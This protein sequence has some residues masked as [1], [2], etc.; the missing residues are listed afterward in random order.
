MHLDE[1]EAALEMSE[2]QDVVTAQPMFPA[3]SF[4]LSSSYTG[5]GA[6]TNFGRGLGSP[7]T[8]PSSSAQAGYGQSTSHRPSQSL[9]ATPAYYTP[10]S[11]GRSTSS[12]M[13]NLTHSPL[14]PTATG[15]A[16]GAGSTGTRYGVALN[17]TGTAGGSPGRKWG[18]GTPTCPKCGKSVFFAEQVGIIPL[19]VTSVC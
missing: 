18:G 8:I 9:D 3:R 15:T 16:V 19:F 4:P 10:V 12:G 13:P 2:S 7:G 17:V 5:P 1:A 6:S 11:L 14:A